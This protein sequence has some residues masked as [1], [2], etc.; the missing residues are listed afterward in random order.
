PKPD[1]WFN[2]PM[3]LAAGLLLPERQIGLSAHDFQQAIGGAEVVLAHATR[4]AEAETV[5]SR[6]LNR[7]TNLV[8][9]LP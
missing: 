4:N 3:R 1:P 6:W 8:A 5:P 9:G 2:R 7:L